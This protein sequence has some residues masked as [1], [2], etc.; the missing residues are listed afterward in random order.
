MLYGDGVTQF[1]PTTALDI[2][3]HEIGHAY[4]QG[5]RLMRSPNP[6]QNI[7]SQT[8]ESLALNE[9]LSD[10]WASCVEN[11]TSQ[12]KDH[13][14]IGEDVMKNG[15][16]CLRSLSNPTTQGYRTGYTT[17][18]NYPNTYNIF[19]W[20][21]GTSLSTFSHV[22][23]T[24]LSHWFYLLSNGGSSTNGKGDS[25][26]V[27]GIG[28]EN[29]AAIVWYTEL[30]YFTAY[31]QYSD[32]YDYTIQAA[33]DL[34]NGNSNSIRVMQVKNAW[35][36][37]GIGSQP[38]QMTLTG[39]WLLCSSGGQY[40]V[41][42]PVSGTLT[43]HKSSN[44]DWVSGSNPATFRA[45]GFSNSS[46]WIQAYYDGIPGP[47]IDVWVGT[48]NGTVVT[49]TAAVCPSSI[50]TYTAQVPGGHSSSYSYSWTYPSNWLYP[51]KYQN[52]IRLQTPASPNYGTVRVA[53]TNACGTSSYS[54]ITVYPSYNC[55]RYFTIYPNPASTDIT[56]TLNENKEININD[57]SIVDLT[58]A[59][60]ITED[61]SVFKVRI[62]NNMG[63]LVSTFTRSGKNFKIPLINMRDGTY[64]IELMNGENIYREQFIVKHN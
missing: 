27:W 44:I 48:F 46:G 61:L 3:A 25:Y 58:T 40:T 50:Y 47:K 56:V 31:S 7:L 42:N 63:I 38:T 1:Y 10:I 8:Y 21:Y 28:M 33:T 59:Q 53:I 30:N 4:C 9:G 39:P 37:V 52:T 36:A 23:S 55:G 26:T 14:K 20:Y 62:Y 60:S 16:S 57:S 2:V 24:V 32:A 34:S 15:F 51:Y 5:V 41:N 43:W 11:W 35:Y 17:E 19:P 13:W 6:S 22:N 12:Y 54:G 18:G 45:N 49:G 29:A 64:I